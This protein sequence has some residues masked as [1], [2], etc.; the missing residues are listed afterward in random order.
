MHLKCLKNDALFLIAGFLEKKGAI[1]MYQPFV[2]WTI[3][4]SIVYQLSS[5]DH[6]DC[7]LLHVSD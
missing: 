6:S 1:E 5:T 2:A 4:D 3:K 7:K